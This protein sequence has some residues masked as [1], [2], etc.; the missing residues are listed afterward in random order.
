[1]MSLLVVL[2]YGLFNVFNSFFRSQNKIKTF[3]LM[4]VIQP[5][6]FLLS[7]LLILLLWENSSSG[8]LSA[9]FF[10]IC[11]AFLIAF[12]GLLN[13]LKGYVRTEEDDKYS[14]TYLFKQTWPMFLTGATWIIIAQTDVAMLGAM[15]SIEE[16]GVYSAATKISMMAAFLLNIINMVLAPKF[17]ELSAKNDIAKLV[18]FSRLGAK[19]IF[20][21]T[22]P[23]FTLFRFF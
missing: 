20:V 15:R 10:S 5:V 12:L 16:V 6:C 9:Y 3:A 17:S 11:F 4:Q 23:S 13:S 7:L 19:I 21:F 18:S 22:F 1:M 8:Y 2:L 14:Y